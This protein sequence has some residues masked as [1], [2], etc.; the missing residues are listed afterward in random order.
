MILGCRF[1]EGGRGEYLKSCC[2]ECLSLG[3]GLGLVIREV[4]WV[5]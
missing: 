1:E 2:Q 3:L 4:Y 5:F